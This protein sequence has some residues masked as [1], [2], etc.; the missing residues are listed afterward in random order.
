[1]TTFDDQ[2]EQAIAVGALRAGDGGPGITESPPRELGPQPVLKYA[3]VEDAELYRRIMRVLYLE[4]RHFGLRLNAEAVAERL[5]EQFGPASDELAVAAKLDYLHSLGAVDR[6]FDSAL[7]R[8]ARELR[9]NRFTYDVTA[10]GKRVEQL[11]EELD[12]L[13]DT[14][15]SLDSGRLASI[16]DCLARLGT[17]LLEDA[18]DPTALKGE[19]EQLLSHVERLHAQASD[20]M[21]RLNRVVATSERIEEDEFDACKGVLLDH[22]QGFRLQLRRHAPEIEATLREVDTR[23]AERM[24]EI[25]VAA[26]EFPALPGHTREQLMVR[27]RAELIEQWRGVRRWFL[28]TGRRGSPWSAL[29]EKVVD[30]IRAV[31]DIAQ[32]IIDRRTDRADR[33]RACEHLARLAYDA[34]DPEA[35]QCVI[36]ALGI[37]HPRHVGVPEDDPDAVGA[38]SQT[39]WSAAPAAAVQAHLRRPGAR[40]PGT[41][42]G[43]GVIDSAALRVR[44]RERSAAER[45]ELSALL[46]RLGGRGA[47][48]LSALGALT[49]GEFR[50]VLHWIGRAFEIPADAAGVRHAES[51]DGRARVRLVPPS[52]SSARARLRV[53]QGVLDAPDYGLE[54]QWR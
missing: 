47:I 50:H 4:H 6:E 34:P 19:L 26:E 37:T 44:V 16:R 20:F 25:I 40:T 5:R 10:A 14:V 7:A 28:G 49:G 48:P 54:V 8:T 53:P 39:P 11:L 30:A 33:S 27:R 9:R 18:P 43:A 31:L 32:R 2:L 42:R 13:A 1:M 41:G 46:E 51:R 22:L 29:A 24:A 36:A 12:Q 15:G 45:R 35:A 52:D 21:A 3:T 38:A 23:G 17:R